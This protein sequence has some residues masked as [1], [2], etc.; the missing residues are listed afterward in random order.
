LT[1]AVLK[2]QQGRQRAEELAGAPCFWRGDGHVFEVGRPLIPEYVTKLFTLAVRRAGPPLIRF[3]G[4]R[5]WD[6]TA[7]LR[8]GVDPKVA[9]AALDTRAR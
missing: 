7:K 1:L 2:E 8:A 3:H 4:T 9:A 6:A 5:H